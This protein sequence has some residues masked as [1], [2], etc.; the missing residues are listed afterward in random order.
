MEKYEKISETQVKITTTDEKVVDLTDLDAQIQD[1]TEKLN[2]INTM[3]VNALAR[4]TKTVQDQFQPTVN[5]YT[6]KIDNLTA[7]KNSITNALGD[8]VNEPVV[9]TPQI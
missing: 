2:E 5:D 3:Y 4:Q 9:I 1:Y 6:S 8:K 7:A